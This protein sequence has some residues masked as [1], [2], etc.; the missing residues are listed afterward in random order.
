MKRTRIEEIKQR[1]SSGTRI[2]LEMMEEESDM[3]GGLEGTVICVDDIGDI[4]VEWDNGRS[5]SL[6]PGVDRFKIIGQ[7]PEPDEGISSMEIQ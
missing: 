6:I 2:A 1:Y 4:L 3:S 7:E 5:L